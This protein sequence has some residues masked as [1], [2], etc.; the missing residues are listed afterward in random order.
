M[1]IKLFKINKRGNQDY[2]KKSILKECYNDD[3]HFLRLF[4][5]SVFSIKLRGEGIDISHVPSGPTHAQP[6]LWSTS[7]T[8]MV[9]F[10]NGQD[11]HTLT[12]QND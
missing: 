9:H 8:R 5:R 2:K 11:E 6:T 4:F 12:H 3:T 1:L 10:F 7:L